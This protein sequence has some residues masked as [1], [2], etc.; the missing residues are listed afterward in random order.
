MH[1][2][3]YNIDMWYFHNTETHGKLDAGLWLA[4]PFEI[5]EWFDN[6][7]EYLN[8]LTELGVTPQEEI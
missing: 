1:E 8:R 6:E 5:L 3:N 7:E 2:Y 4:V